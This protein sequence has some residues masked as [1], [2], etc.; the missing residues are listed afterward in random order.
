MTDEPHDEN[1]K[2]GERGPAARD[3]IVDQQ[4]AVLHE[5]ADAESVGG[6]GVN[7]SE[8]RYGESES[9]A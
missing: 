4:D 2:A 3:G 7:D 5:M 1:D 6:D 9:P 8:R